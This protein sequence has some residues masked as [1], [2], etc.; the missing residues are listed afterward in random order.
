MSGL[1][2]QVVANVLMSDGDTNGYKY[3]VS[4]QTGMWSGFGTTAKVGM[5]I[6]GEKGGSGVVSLSCLGTTRR[7]F[8]RASVNNFT[9]SLPKSLGKLT[10]VDVWHDNSGRHPAWFLQ[11]IVVTDEQTE[12]TWFFF[13]NQ[14]LAVDKGAGEIEISV[15]VAEGKD[16]TA[17]KPL[18]ISR[19]ARR[20][21]EGH[22]W[23]S[24]FS[25]PPHNPFTRCQR[26][27]CCLSFL[28][29]AMVTNAMFYQ[30]GREATDTFKFGPLVMSWTQIKI[31]IQ[32]SIIAV[33]VNVLV[34]LIFRNIK[35][36]S[37]PDIYDTRDK[38]TAS[39]CLP[40]FFVYIGWLLCLLISLT[41]AFFTVLYSLQ[42]GVVVSNEWL[43]SILVSLVQDVLVL[44][45]IKVLAFATLLSLVIKKPPEQ[46]TVI[47]PSF[48]EHG[49]K[50]SRV[51]RSVLRGEKLV[52]T[53]EHSVKLRKALE[54]TKE[55]I[56][57]LVF[58][59]LL[60]VICYGDEDPARYQVTKSLSDIF[61]DFEEVRNAAYYVYKTVVLL[62]FNFHH[63]TAN[64]PFLLPHITYSRDKETF[65]INQGNSRW[66]IIC[67]SLMTSLIEEALILQRNFTLVTIGA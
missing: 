4:I 31:G 59:F 7:L 39:G 47:G 24:V 33:P 36:S 30:F 49:S 44:Q 22:I 32:S 56:S 5:L 41:G 6:T 42:W 64:Y 35:Q 63:H 14:W 53:R 66:V 61:G 10:S 25:K 21:G 17:F 54:A 43:T 45:P 29:T 38:S 19:A 12:E 3:N 46:D 20:L 23:I 1:S 65:L 37:S 40:H 16:L 57:F 9:L 55:I 50:K 62:T 2:L 58:G 27:S 34:V 11:Q 60:L 67:F 26:L 48:F 28:F 51:K 8:A 13:V 18:F 52:T 15:K